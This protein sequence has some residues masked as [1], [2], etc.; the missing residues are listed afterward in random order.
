[1]IRIV[2]IKKIREAGHVTLLLVGNTERKEQQ[3]DQNIDE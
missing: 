2:K 3:I 1:M